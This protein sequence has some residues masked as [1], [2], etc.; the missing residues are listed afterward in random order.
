MRLRN[1]IPVHHGLGNHATQRAWSLAN[2]ERQRIS[3]HVQESRAVARRPR[4]V[5]VIRIATA[6]SERRVYLKQTDS[7]KI[8]RWFVFVTRRKRARRT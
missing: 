8:W 4:D 5:A 2:T 1:K 6:G 3:K 7:G